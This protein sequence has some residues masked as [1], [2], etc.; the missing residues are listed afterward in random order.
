MCS[1]SFGNPGGHALYHLTVVS[2]RVLC[3]VYVNPHVHHMGV[4]AQRHTCTVPG[5]ASASEYLQL[6]RNTYVLPSMY[7]GPKTNDLRD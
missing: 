4:S 5:N 2:T 1:L 7:G 3:I 6:T